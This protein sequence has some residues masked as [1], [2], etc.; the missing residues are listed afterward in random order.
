MEQHLRSKKHIG[1]PLS[2][3]YCDRSFPHISALG[4]HYES[5]ACRRSGMDR[6]TINRSVRVLDKDHYITTG[7]SPQ[8]TIASSGLATGGS[9]NEHTQR[10]ECDCCA[11]TSRGFSSFAALRNHIAS[12]AHDQ[13][14]YKCLNEDCASPF[15]TLSGVAQHVET[16]KC[17][18]AGFDNEQK[19]FYWNRGRVPESAA[20]RVYLEGKP[21]S[22]SHRRSQPRKRPLIWP[23]VILAVIVGMSSVFAPDSTLR[24]FFRS[25]ALFRAIIQSLYRNVILFLC[26]EEVHHRLTDSILRFVFWYTA[27]CQSIAQVIRSVVLFLCSEEVHCWLA[28]STL[29]FT[30]SF[31]ASCQAIFR[32]L[33]KVMLFL[34]S[35]E[36]RCQAMEF[37]RNLVSFSVVLFQSTFLALR[38]VFL[39]LSSEQVR[40]QFTDFVY[41]FVS[42]LTVLSRFIVQ[43]AW[44]I[45]FSLSSEEMRSRLISFRETIGV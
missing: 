45:I 39:F 21:W 9:W 16:G 24:L 11:P 10:Y 5:G 31:T 34:N 4:Q 33:W 12:P 37:F 8:K 23:W 3:R 28:D 14:G 43:T 40:C 2:C 29:R 17:G 44:S 41:N 27:L 35:E 36:V 15:K 25:T 22:S 20:P 30:S 18:L 38:N 19:R 32:T 42:C 1:T 13:K 7:A 26:S 6:H